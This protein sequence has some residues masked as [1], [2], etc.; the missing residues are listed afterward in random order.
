L[1]FQRTTGRGGH[2]HQ[3]GGSKSA[4][5]AEALSG[6]KKIVVC[7]IQTFPFALEAV[8]KLS[9]TQGQTVCGDRR[10]GSQLPDRAKP[11]QSSSRAE[12]RE[13]K[14]LEDGG[15]ISTEDILAAQMASRANDG[16]SP[17][18]PSRLRPRTRPWS[19][20]APVPDPSRKP[21]PDN[22]PKPFTSIRCAKPSKK[23][24]SWTCC[25]TTRPTS[26]P[27]SWP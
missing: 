7:T 5:L 18:W 17:L 4:Q 14:E 1:T 9:A 8:R 22:V 11:R 2:H 23:S 15:E 10:R 25:R 27:S 3:P 13:L 24:S 16:E 20:L 6:D 12:P 26:W 19:C 21:A